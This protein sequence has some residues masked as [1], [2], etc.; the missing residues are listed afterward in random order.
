MIALP[1]LIAVMKIIVEGG[2]DP[3]ALRCSSQQIYFGKYPVLV[4]DLV[5]YITSHVNVNQLC[6]DSYHFRYNLMCSPP[7]TWMQVPPGGGG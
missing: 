1:L 2:A 5:K 4:G 7:G 6:T 3:M